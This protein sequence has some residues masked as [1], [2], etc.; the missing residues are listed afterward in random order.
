ML[1]AG[2]QLHRILAALAL[3]LS[4]AATLAVALPCAY[5]SESGSATMPGGVVTV[6]RSCQSLLAYSPGAVLFFVGPPIVL[7]LVGV[8]AALLRL[9]LV[10]LISGALVIAVGMVL[11]VFS[12]AFFPL[13]FVPAGMCLIAA[14]LPTT[15][16]R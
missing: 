7:V 3:P 9:Q 2:A 15:S 8:L 11:T 10:S 16:A 1:K 6:E 12:F 5:M 13:Y 14:G 4:V